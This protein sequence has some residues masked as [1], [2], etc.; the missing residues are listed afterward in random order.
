MSEHHVLP[1]IVWERLVA[2]IVPGRYGRVEVDVVDGRVVAVRFV[3]SIKVCE[4]RAA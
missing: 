2:F 1:Q 4:D 3:E